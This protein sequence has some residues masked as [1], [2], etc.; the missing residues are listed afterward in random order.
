MSSS[1]RTAA[2]YIR[3]SSDKQTD[4]FSLEA[5]KRQ[6]LER[7]KKDNVE[8]VEI[9]ADEAIS[10]YAHKNRPGIKAMLESAQRN[11][12]EILYFH[13]VDRLSRRVKWA[14]E[15]VEKLVS[16]NIIVI[17][18]EQNF[19][20]GTPEGKLIFTFLS[21]LGEF[22]SDN[23]GKEYSKGKRERAN[24]GYHNSRVPW[25]YVSL[26]IKDK[27]TAVV[28]KELAPII[29]DAFER[30][31]TGIF[32]DQDIA[33]WINQ[34]GLKT[35]RGRFFSKDTVRDILQNPF[36]AGLVRYR[37]T[38]K[39]GQDYRRQPS[40]LSPGKHKAIISQEL[41][42]RSQRVRAARR[43]KGERKPTTNRVY[44]A[45]GLMRC[46][47]CGRRLRAQTVNLR[48]QYYRE[49]SRHNGY[50]DC[51][52]A[53]RSVQAS[54]V[55]ETITSIIEAIDLPAD[56]MRQLKHIINQKEAGSDPKTTRTKLRANLRRL[57]TN[58]EHGLYDEDEQEYWR[59]IDEIKGKLDS[60]KTQPE[61]TFGLAA[62]RLLSIQGSWDLATK[63]EKRELVQMLFEKISWN[64]ETK[65]L[66]WVTPRQGFRTLFRL[67]GCMK[68]IRDDRFAFV[69]HSITDRAFENED[70]SKISKD[71]EKSLSSN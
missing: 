32:S 10:A 61:A 69:T 47:A 51:L 4:S 33:N 31:A 55:E 49:V 37:G 6:I 52:F 58:Y 39:K 43:M 62:S 25:G 67:I 17:A 12:F 53:G 63:A 24:Q 2:G 27:M 7:A 56:W 22:Y 8:I 64:F 57:R 3:F 19:D 46:A 30:Y 21:S 38:K 71:K 40:T 65:S 15:I 20:L 28:E 60:V 13:K 59:R 44:L 35:P 18:V 36:Y 68:P 23:L 16:L 14:L 9:F 70:R 48:I 29:L 45:N 41:F 1:N 66:A 54:D 42:D 11:E 5:Q 50:G 34:Q 26:E